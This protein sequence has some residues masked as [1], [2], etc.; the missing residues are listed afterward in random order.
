MPEVYHLGLIGYPIEH[1]L[2]PYLHRAALQFCGL[3]G[4]YQLFPV[5]DLPQGDHSLRDVIGKVR[6]GFLD[7]VN[8]TIPHKQNVIPLVDR[9]TMTAEA[10]GAVNTI[11]KKDGTLYG[12]NSDVGGFMNDLKRLGIGKTG[13]RSALVLGAGGAARAVVWGLLIGGWQVYI[14]ARRIEQAQQVVDWVSQKAC[15]FDDAMIGRL[16]A[17]PLETKTLQ[18]R[19]SSEPTQLIV[20]TTPLGMASHPPG[21]AWPKEVPFPQNTLVYDLVYTPAETELMRLAQQ[22][23]IPAYNGMGMLVEQAAIAFEIWT[24]LQAP[25]K[26]MWEAVEN[27]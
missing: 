17:I 9:L 20:N 7:G 25:R 12:E 10:V 15:T 6:R 21:A 24:G 1:S 4:D 26:A 27:L 23:G 13:N 16:C 5:T 22:A 11:Y 19:I 14:L 8:V 3:A 2:S 18:Q